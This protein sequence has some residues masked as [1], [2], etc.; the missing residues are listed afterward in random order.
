M[1]SSVTM[2]RRVSL[3]G[4]GII[5]LA[6]GY[7]PYTITT[8]GANPQTI[9]I[10]RADSANLQVYLNNQVVAGAQSSLSGAVSPVITAGSNP[11]SAVEAAMDNWN[12]A[13]NSAGANVNYLALQSTA[14]VHNSSDCVNVIGMASSSAD[15]S[16]LGFVSA[17]SFGAVAI[18]ANAYITG[19]GTVCGGTTSVPAG[20]IIDSDVILNPY[21]TFSTDNSANTVDLQGTITHELGHLIGM[22]HSE[23]LGTTMYPFTSYNVKEWRR[24][25]TDE[26]AFTVATY[27]V[28]AGTTATISGT[29]TLSSS[30]VGFGLVTLMDQTKGK[31]F[32]TMTSATGVYSTQVSPGSYI[33]YAEPFNSYVGPQNIYSTTTGSV[34]PAQVTT[35]YEPTFFGS[36]SAPTVVTATAAATS[37]ANIAVTG[38]TSVLTAPSYGFGAAGGNGDISAVHSLSEGAT[39]VSGQ[40]LDI[41]FSGGGVSPTTS[42]LVFGTGVSVTPGTTKVDSTGVLRAT[43]VIAAQTNATLDSIWLVSGTSAT[44]FSGGLVVEPVTPVINN[45]EDAESARTSFTSGQWAAIY[46]TSLAGS[47][48]TWNASLDFTGGV[49]P[50]SPLPS[51]LDGVTVTVNSVPASVYFVCGTCSPAQINFLTP[52]GLATGPATVVVSNNGSASAAFS[53]TVVQAS[54][55]FFYYGAGSSL[56]PLAVHLSD[57]KIVGDPTALGGTEVAHAGETIEMFVNGIA[58]ATGG[59]IVSATQF[60]Q[61][62]AITTG[63]TSL[64]TSAP[65]LVAAGEFQV[66]VTI[67]AGL[68]A[69]NYPLTMTVPN[70]STST[71]GVTIVLPVGP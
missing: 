17:S 68:A 58:P 39:V 69:G 24:I 65:Y 27:P 10:N 53:T 56:Y 22:N 48:R 43:L 46:G 52:S 50:G 13:A 20:T 21:I 7:I 70:G 47:T 66:N 5:P 51:S 6:F 59:V 63:A 8:T 37:T 14:S 38:G 29:V 45:V 2:L 26:K 41:G 36:T 49:T 42:I 9:Q 16:V 64:A 25:T 62:V 71:S 3:L 31:T 32:Q 4:A 30:P 23:L 33:V 60:S 34:N 61:Q 11:A 35:G 54:P 67:P 44:A 18:T 19:A 1:R 40:S 28:S 12:S 55:S 15:L 57:G